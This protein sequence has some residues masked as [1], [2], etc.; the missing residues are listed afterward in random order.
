MDRFQQ[1]V[2]K[3]FVIWFSIGLLLVGFSLLPSWLEWAN[4]VFLFLSGTYAAFYLWH[5]LPNARF[6]I[7]LI[8]FGS[9]LIESF[10]TKTGLLFGKYIYTTEFGPL[11]IGVPITMGPAWL[12]VIGA[13]YA[14]SRLFS[15]RYSTL[16]IVP[17]L[18]VWLDLAIDPV[19]SLNQYWVWQE[20]GIYYGIPT[21]NFLG[22]YI[23]ALFFS[24]F[25]AKYEEPATNLQLE[26]NNQKLFLM[27]HV[28]FGVTAW[29]SGLHG[30][31]FV[32]C[33]VILIYLAYY[34]RYKRRTFNHPVD[35]P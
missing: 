15:I 27:L 29:T 5:V 11:W 1:Y 25:I 34:S 10:G 13:S 26:R 12:S 4:A 32:T 7:P 23:T 31:L 6:I 19:A 20:P 3:L 35:R 21:Q 2:W 24:L 28:L 16:L 17:L 33:S 18:T 14:F 22:W 8:F 9:I 30:V